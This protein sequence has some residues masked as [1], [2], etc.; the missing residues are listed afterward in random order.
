ME[1]NPQ[2]DQRD[3]MLPLI[4]LKLFV[5]SN[6]TEAANQRESQKIGPEAPFDQ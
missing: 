4:Q 3:A 1:V 6:A 5:D 2:I